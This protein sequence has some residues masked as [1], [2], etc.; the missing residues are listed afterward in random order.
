MLDYLYFFFRYHIIYYI[1]EMNTMDYTK[2]IDEHFDTDV[3]NY[4]IIR[5]IKA[6]LNEVEQDRDRY[7]Y[8]NDENGERI[9]RSLKV[10]VKKYLNRTP[11]YKWNLMQYYQLPEN[12]NYDEAL[13]E[14]MNDLFDTVMDVVNEDVPF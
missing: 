9:Y 3:A 10:I 4:P 6:I 13:E 14:F 2:Y 5:L 11:S 12:A 7:T 8:E 1:K